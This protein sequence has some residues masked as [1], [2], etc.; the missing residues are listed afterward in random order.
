MREYEAYRVL[1][2]EEL[3]DVQSAA[4]TVARRSD[5]LLQFIDSYRQIS[6]L[7]PPE[8]KRIALADLFDLAGYLDVADADGY[9]LIVIGTS[10]RQGLAH[11]IVGSVAENV[12]RNAL[13]FTPEGGGVG[14]LRRDHE[15]ALVLGRHEASGQRGHAEI[16]RRQ[17]GG[18]DD[19]TSQ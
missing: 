19:A 10:G 9:D 7:A 18:E 16:D 4:S 17:H 11:F 15:V 3:E 14:K 5:S 12:V 6:R 2:R 8:K 1:L 13:R